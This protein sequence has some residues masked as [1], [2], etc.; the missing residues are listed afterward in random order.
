MTT[1]TTTTVM[2]RHGIGG[3]GRSYSSGG[4]PCTLS[5][6]V[7]LR[8]NKRGSRSMRLKLEVDEGIAVSLS[9]NNGASHQGPGRGYD[10]TRQTGYRR[11][12]VAVPQ[13]PMHQHHAGGDD[14]DLQH[15]A[16]GK[17]GVALGVSAKHAAQH[18]RGDGE[19][20]RSKKYPRDADRRVSSES[21]EEFCAEIVRPSRVFEKDAN[22]ALDDQIRTVQQTPN[23]EG[24]G[25]AVPETAEKHNNDEINRGTDWSDLIAA[26]RNVKVVAQKCGK[27]NVPASPEIGKT[28][29]CVGKTEIILQMKAEAERGADRAN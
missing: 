1:S 3:I 14:G 12:D 25:G 24:P 22:D 9:E 6:G 5:L 20:G 11:F 10:P 7:G 18:A 19:I 4:T 29:G 17:N 15:F 2:P 16:G 28:N 26:E 21:G 8:K 27:R 23:D 13:R